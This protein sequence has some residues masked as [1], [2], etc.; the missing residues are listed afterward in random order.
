MATIIST[1]AKEKSTYIVTCAFTDE[2][3][4]AVTPDSIVWT[5]AD[6]SGNV[7]NSRDQ[8]SV[9]TPA[10]SIDI[11]LSGDDLQIGGDDEAALTQVGRRIIVEAVYDS[12]AGSNLPLKAEAAFVLENL[13]KI[14]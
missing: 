4:D 10:A 8:V 1:K 14:S 7:I 12:D 9:A 2:D 13:T 5:L 11:V 3:G 6:S